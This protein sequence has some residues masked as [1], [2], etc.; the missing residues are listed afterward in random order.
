[1]FFVF[2][3]SVTLQVKEFIHLKGWKELIIN[4]NEK[5]RRSQQTTAQISIEPGQQTNSN[6]HRT[7]LIDAY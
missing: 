2:I 1:M 3:L 5:Y 7:S 4:V 6:S